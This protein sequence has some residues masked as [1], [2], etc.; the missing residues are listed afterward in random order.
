MK[1]NQKLIRIVNFNCAIDVSNNNVIYLVTVIDHRM[2]FE[3]ITLLRTTLEHCFNLMGFA[4]SPQNSMTTCKCFIYTS[5]FCYTKP[6]FFFFKRPLSPSCHIIN[7]LLSFFILR[8][9]VPVTT[10]VVFFMAFWKSFLIPSSILSN[11]T[12]AYPAVFGFMGFLES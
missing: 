8:W 12:L 7:P 5:F 11:V 9:L 4:D 10:S 6:L 3:W 2:Y 1:K